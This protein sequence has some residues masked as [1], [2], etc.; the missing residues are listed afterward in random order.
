MLKP[1]FAKASEVA[2][3]VQ[4]DIRVLIKE[5]HPPL[6]GTANRVAIALTIVARVAAVQVDVPNITAIARSLGRRPVNAG[7]NPGGVGIVVNAVNVGLHQLF[8]ARQIPVVNRALTGDRF[9]RKR[10][11][12]VNRIVAIEVR[13]VVI[14]PRIGGK[15]IAE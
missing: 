4:H 12:G 6:P 11:A 3:Q 8:F 9:F 5:R 14:A 15:K 7:G 13:A 10:A 2:Q 1:P